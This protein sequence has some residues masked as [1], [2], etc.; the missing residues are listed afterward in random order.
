MLIY[1]KKI[2]R[3]RYSNN[4]NFKIRAVGGEGARVA[5]TPLGPPI[6]SKLTLSTM[7]YIKLALSVKIFFIDPFTKRH[8]P[9]YNDRF[10]KFGVLTVL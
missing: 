1:T 10:P 4:R 3:K 9:V 6:I 8:K 7:Q 5:F 2:I